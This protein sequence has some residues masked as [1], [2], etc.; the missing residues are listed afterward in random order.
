MGVPELSKSNQKIDLG[1][2][3]KSRVDSTRNGPPGAK[4]SSATG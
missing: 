4:N 1:S 2:S 3:I